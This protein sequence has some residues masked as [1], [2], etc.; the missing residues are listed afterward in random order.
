MICAILMYVYFGTDNT[1]DNTHQSIALNTYKFTKRTQ[2]YIHKKG[3]PVVF[4]HKA[5]LYCAQAFML[6]AF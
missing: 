5:R 2:L 4:L 1:F 6:F 3:T